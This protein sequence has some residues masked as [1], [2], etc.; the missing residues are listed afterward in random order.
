M[1]PGLALSCASSPRFTATLRG[2]RA[3]PFNMDAAERTSSTRKR[4]VGHD[5]RWPLSARA[6]ASER[7]NVAIPA[8]LGFCVMPK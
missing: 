8:A 3:P 4:W 2:Y 7:I 6:D 5:E 1:T